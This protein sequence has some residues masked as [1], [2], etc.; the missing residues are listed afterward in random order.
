M[1]YAFLI[2]ALY[3]LIVAII[4]YRKGVKNH[5]HT[6]ETMIYAFLCVMCCILVLIIVITE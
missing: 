6:N 1:T 4:E 2:A 5:L 3:F